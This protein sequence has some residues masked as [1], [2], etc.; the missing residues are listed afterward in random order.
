MDFELIA[1]VC[2]KVK[3]QDGAECVKNDLDSVNAR[4]MEMVKWSSTR[5]KNITAI[6]SQADVDVQVS[7]M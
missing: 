6:L 4:Y 1:S 7:C 3:H 5:L 2:K